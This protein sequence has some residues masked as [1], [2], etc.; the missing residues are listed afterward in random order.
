MFFLVFF[1]NVN[2]N[3]IAYAGVDKKEN[4]PLALWAGI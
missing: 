3:N 1:C 4:L 2:F